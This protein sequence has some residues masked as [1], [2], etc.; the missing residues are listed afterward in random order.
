MTKTPDDMAALK[1]AIDACHLSLARKHPQQE[2]AYIRDFRQLSVVLEAARRYAEIEPMLRE[3]VQADKKLNALGFV[4]PEKL[5]DL[6]IGA[7]HAVEKE[8]SAFFKAIKSYSN[9]GLATGIGK[10]LTEGER[11]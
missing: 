4:I 11:A 7:S 6:N 3:L 10:V 9:K 1:E 5:S 2:E 8:L